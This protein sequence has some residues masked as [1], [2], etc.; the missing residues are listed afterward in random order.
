MN[1][2][3]LGFLIVG[4]VMLVLSTGLSLSYAMMPALT[5]IERSIISAILGVMLW[6]LVLLVFAGMVLV[7]EIYDWLGEC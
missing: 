3:Q 6:G 1:N 7:V 2:K 4:A 5:W